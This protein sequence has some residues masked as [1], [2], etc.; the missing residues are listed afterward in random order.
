M[1][2]NTLMKKDCFFQSNIT[3]MG[4]LVEGSAYVTKGSMLKLRSSLLK[5]IFG[6]DTVEVYS[7]G[8]NSEISGVYQTTFEIDPEDKELLSKVKVWIKAN[9]E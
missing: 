5:E 4:F 9:K 6:I 3:E 1:F 2:E 7:T 8:F